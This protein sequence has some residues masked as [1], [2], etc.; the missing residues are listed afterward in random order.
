MKHLSPYKQRCRNLYLYHLQMKEG[1]VTCENVHILHNHFHPDIL[2]KFAAF[3][4]K[5]GNEKKRPMKEIRQRN[6]EFN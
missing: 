3:R 5:E 2:L 6:S 1:D 4:K